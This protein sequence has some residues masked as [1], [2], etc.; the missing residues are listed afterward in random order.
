[1]M[2][3]LGVKITMNRTI[4]SA[5]NTS[6]ATMKLFSEVSGRMNMMRGEEKEKPENGK[7]N[8]SSKFMRVS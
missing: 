8:N 5:Q 4:H 2:M 1:M 7:V 3:N 6:T